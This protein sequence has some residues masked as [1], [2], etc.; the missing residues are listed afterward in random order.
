MA[1]GAP[2]AWRADT[3]V[4]MPLLLPLLACGAPESPGAPSAA[5]EIPPG[6]LTIEQLD[7]RRSRIGESALLLTEEQTMLVDVGHEAH[8]QTIREALARHGRTHVDFVVLTHFHTDH[9][10]GFDTLF[11]DGTL[12]VGEVVWRGAVNLDDANEGQLDDVL[13]CLGAN[14]P[15]CDASGC[16][17]PYVVPFGPATLT[18]F[19]ADGVV[20][21]PDA[22]VELDRDLDDENARSLGGVVS[23]G[24]FDWLFAGDLTGG[25]KSTPDLETAVVEA[26]P[27]LPPI[28]VMQVNHHGISSSTNAVWAGLLADGDAHAVVGANNVY[29]DAPSEETLAALAPHL[30]NGHVWVTE[31]GLLGNTDARTVVAHGA[32]TVRVEADGRYTIQGGETSG[33]WMA[34]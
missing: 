25:G 28:D 31:T 24:D 6:T 1:H 11:C 7:L 18:V 20:G 30:G 23:F 10:G 4:R 27:A 16:D 26:N 19:L 34:R 29:L 14:T 32:V 17:L 3:M 15:L 2:V 13:D 22:S 21:T 5:T 12:T 9:I 33:E 8:A